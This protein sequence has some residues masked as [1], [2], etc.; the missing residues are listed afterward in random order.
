M[1]NIGAR[2]IAH[3][4]DELGVPAYRANDSG[5]DD[6]AKHG[7]AFEVAKIPQKDGAVEAGKTSVTDYNPVNLD[8]EATGEPH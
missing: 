5:M 6:T 2:V 8:E 1:L 4:T 7:K 3:G